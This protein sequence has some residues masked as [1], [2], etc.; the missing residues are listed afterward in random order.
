MPLDD[1]VI[2]PIKQ[3][4]HTNENKDNNVLE[5][6]TRALQDTS[7]YEPLEMKKYNHESSKFPQE[8]A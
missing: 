4:V 2:S 5:K 1:F 6:L 8:I 3:Y 7:V